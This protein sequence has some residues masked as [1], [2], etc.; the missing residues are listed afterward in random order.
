M[1]FE[2]L[3]QT[4]H[5]P[6]TIRRVTC[7]HIH[8]RISSHIEVVRHYVVGCKIVEDLPS[9]TRSVDQVTGP[10]QH[11]AAAD[12]ECVSWYDVDRG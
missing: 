10:G 4:Y 1:F 5:S 9:G 3:R 2:A 12:T 6:I 8:R 7:G 11:E